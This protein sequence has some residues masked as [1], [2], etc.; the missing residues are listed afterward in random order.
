MRAVAEGA[1][2]QGSD[3][4]RD[5]LVYKTQWCGA[6]RAALRFLDKHAIPYRAIDIDEDDEAA[7]LVQALN[8]GNRSV[9]TIMINGVHAMTEPSR[10]E[11][12]KAFS[13]DQD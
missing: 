7:A 13:D 2:S 4:P 3:S 11:L 10:K 9:P 12:A 8:H 1:R 6:S 5:V